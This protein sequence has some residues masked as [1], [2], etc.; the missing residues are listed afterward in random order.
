MLLIPT[1]SLLIDPHVVSI[2][3]LLLTECSPTILIRSVAS[4]DC[5]APFIFGADPLD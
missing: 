4:V 5:L 1:F 2:V 3:L